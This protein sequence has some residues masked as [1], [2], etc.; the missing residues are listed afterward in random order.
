MS[1]CSNR[2]WNVGC[3]IGRGVVQEAQDTVAVY[4][5]FNKMRG[6]EVEVK[7]Q[8]GQKFL[9]DRL[10]GSVEFKKS[11]S[12]ALNFWPTVGDIAPPQGMLRV[13]LTTHMKKFF[14]VGYIRV[15]RRLRPKWRVST[16]A[17]LAGHNQ[18]D[19]FLAGLIKKR[20]GR[21]IGTSNEIRR[22]TMASDPDKA[23]RP[24]SLTQPAH[25]A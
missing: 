6:V 4:G 23:V 20:P 9:R 14:E 18:G 19:L 22:D 2:T 15:L 7:S 8:C 1:S 5:H 21:R 17:R 12:K 16:L 10:Q 3:V 11:F 13:K 25:K 24:K